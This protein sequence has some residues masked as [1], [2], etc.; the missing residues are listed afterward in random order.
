MEGNTNYCGP[1][2]ILMYDFYIHLLEKNVPLKG[3]CFFIQQDDSVEELKST[4]ELFIYSPKLRNSSS[5]LKEMR[6]TYNIWLCSLLTRKSSEIWEN[7]LKS[8]SSSSKTCSISLVKLVVLAIGM[9]RL[10]L[11][12][13]TLWYFQI[14][15]TLRDPRQTLQGWLQWRVVW[16]QLL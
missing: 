15:W 10:D 16:L 12:P 5:S 9:L 11:S 3:K 14:A 8:S 2:I 1:P 6:F 7:R 4:L 13:V